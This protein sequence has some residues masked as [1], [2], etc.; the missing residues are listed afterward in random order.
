MG[1]T[2]ALAALGTAFW[3][4]QAI[5]ASDATVPTYETVVTAPPLPAHD[6]GFSLGRAGAKSLPGAG[7]DLGR[8]LENAPGVARMA[9]A[10][11]GLVLWGSAP[12]ESRVLLDDVE[13]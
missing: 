11:D 12:Q 1:V 4:A 8:A 13:I 2:V 10:G 3:V 5:E 6:G 9:P 7:G